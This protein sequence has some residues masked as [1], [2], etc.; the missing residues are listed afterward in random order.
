M[1]DDERIEEI[2][3]RFGCLVKNVAG[4]WPGD[5][6]EFVRSDAYFGEYG[7]ALSNAIA[8][9]L[10]HPGGFTADEVRQIEEL[11]EIAQLSARDDPWLGKLRDWVVENQ[12]AA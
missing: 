9:G 3:R 10:N 5:G 4:K 1:T 12:H 6:V 2:Q 7:Q 11:A 8:L